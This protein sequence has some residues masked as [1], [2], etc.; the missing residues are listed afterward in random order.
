MWLFESK[1]SV[2][3]ASH[4]IHTIRPHPH[5]QVLDIKSWLPEHPGGSSIIPRQ[6]L[7]CDCAR[8]F[9]VRAGNAAA[10]WAC[11]GCGIRAWL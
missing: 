4:C 2:K 11:S 10:G 3:I 1:S 8:F 6:S 5:A 9:E 7:N